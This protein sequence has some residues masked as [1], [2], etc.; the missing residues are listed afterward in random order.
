MEKASWLFISELII[1]N[2][3][4]IYQQSLFYGL[5]KN[6]EIHV[7]NFVDKSYLYEN[8]SPKRRSQ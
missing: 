4:M 3:A 6:I 7:S 5:F 8:E 2:E 1:F